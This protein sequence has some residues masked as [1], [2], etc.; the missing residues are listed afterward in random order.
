MP[1][2]MPISVV[3]RAICRKKTLRG[4]DLFMYI[5]K[6]TQAMMESGIQ[7]VRPAI[8]ISRQPTQD[9]IRK[10]NAAAIIT[11]LNPVA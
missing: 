1:T 8:L 7:A 4:Q 2:S 6:N 10:S 5:P 11:K 3:R 9:S